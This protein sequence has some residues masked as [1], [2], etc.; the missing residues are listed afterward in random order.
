VDFFDLD[1]LCMP[2]YV[3]TA[4]GIAVAFC[5]EINFMLLTPVIFK[6]LHKFSTFQIAKYQSCLAAVDIVFRCE[7][8]LKF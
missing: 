1:L 8:I 7:I 2:N 6:E 4:A 3:I 5:A